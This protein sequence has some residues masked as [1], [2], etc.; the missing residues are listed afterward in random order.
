MFKMLCCLKIYYTFLLSI[1]INTSL[2]ITDSDNP[3]AL[4]ECLYEQAIISFD[5]KATFKEFKEAYKEAANESEKE[6]CLQEVL[7]N[8]QITTAEI[9][10]RI[11]PSHAFSFIILQE[12]IKQQNIIVE[13]LL[14]PAL[15]TEICLLGTFPAS[16][17]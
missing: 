17:L 13:C 1:Q 3:V 6:Q 8:V 4:L 7:S 12:L 14:A 10:I 5:N 16:P 15:S 2:C 9:I 11:A